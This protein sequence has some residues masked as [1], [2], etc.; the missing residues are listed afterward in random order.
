AGVVEGNA[1]VEDLAL[2]D[3]GSSGHQLVRRDEVDGAPLVLGA[4][5]APIRQALPQRAEVLHQYAPRF[6]SNTF[7]RLW[8]S[9]WSICASVTPRSFNAGMTSLVMCR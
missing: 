1:Q 6:W 5:P 2:L 7:F 8:I 3:Q 9:I 4:P